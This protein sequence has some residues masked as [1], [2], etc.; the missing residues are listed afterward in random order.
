LVLKKTINLFENSPAGV[1]F[2]SLDGKFEEVNTALCRMLN[3]TKSELLQLKVNDITH[4]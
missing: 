2:I 3:Y 4:P 1:A